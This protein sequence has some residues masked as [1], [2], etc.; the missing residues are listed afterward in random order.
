MVKILKCY[1]YAKK[2]YGTSSKGAIFFDQPCRTTKQTT[3]MSS[4]FYYLL[5]RQKV[6]APE[7][8][9]FAS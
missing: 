1:L 6:V 5:S 4:S 8:Q 2:S 7:D 9:A 3:N